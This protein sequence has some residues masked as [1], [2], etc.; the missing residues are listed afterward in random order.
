[1]TDRECTEA[2]V[3]NGEAYVFVAGDKVYKSPTRISRG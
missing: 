2:C 1:M 3:K